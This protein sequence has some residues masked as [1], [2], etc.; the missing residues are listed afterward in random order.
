VVIGELVPG[1]LAVRARSIR[2]IPA[3]LT[4]VLPIPVPGA[5]WMRTSEGLGD[6]G[7]FSFLYCFARAQFSW[8]AGCG[9]PTVQGRLFGVTSPDDSWAGGRYAA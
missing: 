6:V 1:G 4:P 9:E 5:C 2:V 3:P 7:S 8:T